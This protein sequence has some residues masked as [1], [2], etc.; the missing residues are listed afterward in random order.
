MR[1]IL[2]LTLFSSLL[3]AAPAYHGKRTFTQPDGSKVEYRNRGDEYLHWR[4]NQEGDILLLNHRGDALEYAKIKEGNLVPSGEVY[5]RSKQLRSVSKR[6]QSHRVSRED[7]KVLYR[8][9]R[10]QKHRLHRTP[11]R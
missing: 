3:F 2:F 10:Q 7:L 6:S 8:Q 1:Q 9:K 5:N 4:E 11:S